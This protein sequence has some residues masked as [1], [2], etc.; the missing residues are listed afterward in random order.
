MHHDETRTPAWPTMRRCADRCPELQRESAQTNR[1]RALV[2][3]M[4][5]RLPPGDP[6]ADDAL[7]ALQ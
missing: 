5:D 1:L 2:A 6:L 7:E 4:L 3:R